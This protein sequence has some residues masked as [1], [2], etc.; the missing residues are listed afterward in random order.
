VTH[1]GL[2]ANLRLRRMLVL[3]S[4]AVALGAVAALIV[5]QTGRLTGR[6]DPV[7]QLWEMLD[8]QLLQ[9]LL[10][11]IA[12]LMVG[13]GFSRELRQRTLVYHLVR[14]VSRTTVF[15]AR[16]VSGVVP[17]AIVAAVLFASTLLFSGVS[18]PPSVWLAALLT[19]VCGVAVL[20]AVY[21]MLSAVFRRGLI[22]GLLYT[23]MVEGVVA[24]L[25]GTIQKLS[26]RFHLRGLH[27]GLTDDAFTEPSSALARMLDPDRPRG[28]GEMVAEMVSGQ[29]AYDPPGVALLVLACIAVGLLAFGIYKVRGRDFALKD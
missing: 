18:L 15:L 6:D 29:T 19:S 1:W 9:V 17:A 21:Y 23:F 22:A 10:P 27:H 28:P 7:F 20:G 26:V 5:T 4:I 2:R 3:L 24:G 25:P 11:L 16:Y 14:P 8:E 13:P 12:L